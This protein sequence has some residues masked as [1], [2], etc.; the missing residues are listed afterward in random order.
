MN[1]GLT[2]LSSSS[3]V[4]E[5]RNDLLTLVNVNN[6]HFGYILYSVLTQEIAFCA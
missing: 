3:A 4:I 2:V 6:S 1:D 5:T